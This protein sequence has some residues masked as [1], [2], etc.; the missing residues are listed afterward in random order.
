LTSFQRLWIDVAPTS[1]NRRCF[2]VWKSISFPCFIFDVVSM[3]KSR[4]KCKWFNVGVKTSFRHACFYVNLT[5]TQCVL[6]S[7]FPSKRTLAGHF[8]KI[9]IHLTYTL[10]H[11]KIFNINAID[12]F[13]P[14]VS[15]VFTTFPICFIAM[16]MQVQG[17]HKLA[18]H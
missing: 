2:N 15:L 11:T 14:C 6:A 18:S 3:F 10:I 4:W 7:A 12:L 16:P 8:F 1:M 9:F 5:Q 13:L 17:W